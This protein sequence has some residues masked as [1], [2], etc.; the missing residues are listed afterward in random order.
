MNSA[1]AWGG[2]EKWVKLAATALKNNHNVFLAYRNAVVGSR[3]PV[4]KL[5]LPFRHEADLQTILQLIAFVKKHD[6]DVLIPSKRKEY[7]IAGIVRKACRCL[8]I[9]RLGIVRD[10]KNNPLQRYI[11]NR[12]ADGVIVNAEPIKTTLLDSGYNDP[13]TIRVIYNG[14]DKE[15]I[16]TLAQKQCPHLPFSF[17]VSSMGDLNSRKGFDMLLRGFAKF[18]QTSGA[19]DAC[20]V[21]IG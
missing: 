20:L 12:L 18:L 4:N 19:D 6:I 5:C 8:N 3:I 10:L 17:I 15:T 7:V 11:F 16:V 9:L 21:I 1:R 14:L 2:N 13:A